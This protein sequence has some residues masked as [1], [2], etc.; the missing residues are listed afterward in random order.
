MNYKPKRSKGLQKESGLEFKA[1]A[2]DLYRFIMLKFKLK[3]KRKT[4]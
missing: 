1:L 4:K 2:L 3:F